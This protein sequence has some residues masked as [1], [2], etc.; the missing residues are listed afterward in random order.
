MYA[1]RDALPGRRHGDWRTWRD[2]RADDR[3]PEDR[4]REA[5]NVPGWNCHYVQSTDMSGVASSPLLKESMQ[6]NVTRGRFLYLGGH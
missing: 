4:L 1:A 3:L 6:N 2:R 5:L